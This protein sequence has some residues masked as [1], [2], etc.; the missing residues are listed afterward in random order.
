MELPAML[1]VAGSYAVA[2]PDRR[3]L[4]GLRAACYA[5]I[6]RQ[7]PVRPLERMLGRV[8]GSVSRL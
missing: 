3:E 1:P 6:R 5:T 7:P 2:P 4:V 8:Y